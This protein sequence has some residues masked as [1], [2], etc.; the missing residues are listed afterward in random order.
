MANRAIRRVDRG[1][2]LHNG[3]K[4]VRDERVVLEKDM[5]RFTA[6]VASK[7]AAARTDARCELAHASP[8]MRHAIPCTIQVLPSFLRASSLRFAA[9]SRRL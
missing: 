9:A 3:A 2:N 4:A 5:C 1:Q 7:A 8:L 6:P